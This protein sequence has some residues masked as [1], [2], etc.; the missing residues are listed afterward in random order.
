MH[1]VVRRGQRYHWN[2]HRLL[3]GLHWSTGGTAPSFKKYLFL[4][5]KRYP[6]SASLEELKGRH[7]TTVGETQTCPYFYWTFKDLRLK[8]AKCKFP[9]HF[10]GSR[11]IK[12]PP[13]WRSMMSKESNTLW[14]PSSALKFID[15]K[16]YES[17]TAETLGRSVKFIIISISFYP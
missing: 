11:Q 16:R 9:S 12:L 13:T 10:Q 6:E 5:F 3:S 4:V 7:R 15:Q 8:K 2:P 17:Q 14:I 1:G